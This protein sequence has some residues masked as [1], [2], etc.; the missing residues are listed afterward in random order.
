MARHGLRIRA[1]LSPDLAAMMDYLRGAVERFVATN[2]M[3]FDPRV[4]AL[5][6]RYDQVVGLGPDA[7]FTADYW[8]GAV[9]V[10]PTDLLLD[11]V[12]KFRAV[13]NAMRASSA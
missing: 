4:I 13:E 12:A 11:L 10:E 2:M 9:V 1:R 5:A 7:L 3:N 6:R 8:N